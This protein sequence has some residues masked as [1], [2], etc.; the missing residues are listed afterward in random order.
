M[1]QVEEPKWKK[2]G[3]KCAVYFV[4]LLLAYLPGQIHW[5]SIMVPKIDEAKAELLAKINESKCKVV[6][7]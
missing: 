3:R 6:S 1:P 4:A 5:S 2:Y 7:Q